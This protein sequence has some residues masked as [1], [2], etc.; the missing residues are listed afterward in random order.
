MGLWVSL[1]IYERYLPTCRHTQLHSTIFLKTRSCLIPGSNSLG[2]EIAHVF[3]VSAMYSFVFIL[4]PFSENCISWLLVCWLPWVCARVLSL[5]SHVWL[6]A[7]LWN[8]ARQTPLTMRFPRQ[9]YWSGLPCPPPGSLAD[10]GIEPTSL[11]FLALAGRIFYTSAT[12]DHWF[13]YKRQNWSSH[14]HLIDEETDV[15]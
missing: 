3:I 10:P 5:F 9:E 2:G 6:F 14:A 1:K 11:T 4:C 7:T 12:W 15:K 8:V 13:P